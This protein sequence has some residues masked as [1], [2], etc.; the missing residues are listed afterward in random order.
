MLYRQIP[1]TTTNQPKKQQSLN[2]A[3]NAFYGE[4]N[5]Q[6][7]ENFVK[8]DDYEYQENVKKFYGADDVDIPQ[9]NKYPTPKK[10]VL[11]KR[12]SNRNKTQF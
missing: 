12:N 7:E 2:T 4:S 8:N 10:K 9:I 1:N 3:L 11:R 6:P 5:I